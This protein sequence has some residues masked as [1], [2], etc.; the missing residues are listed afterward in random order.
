MPSPTLVSSY[1]EKSFGD[2]PSGIIL[3][4]ALGA[5]EVLEHDSGWIHLL[6][7]LPEIDEEILKRTSHENLGINSDLE[8]LRK[9]KDEVPGIG[10]Q[11][12]RGLTH[13]LQPA[14]RNLRHIRLLR[15]DPKSNTSP[16]VK[17]ASW[18]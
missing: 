9:I 8:A 18:L 14:V 16:Q 13:E 10:A 5:P 15:H 11:Y 2:P 17:S 12:Y 4:P 7:F 3:Y 1:A 6:M